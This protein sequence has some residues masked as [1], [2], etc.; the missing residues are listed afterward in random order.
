MIISVLP[1]IDFPTISFIPSISINEDEHI[2]LQLDEFVYDKDH[3][4]S[5]LTWSVIKNYEKNNNNSLYTS[6]YK[7]SRRYLSTFLNQE[8]LL[9]NDY[10]LN[11]EDVI[12]WVEI[13]SKNQIARIQ[14]PPNYFG[15]DIPILLQV[16]DPLNAK[17]IK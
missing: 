5:L 14:P 17:D 10:S 7:N 11:N 6:L 15:T 9:P 12:N 4:D 1:V 2:V 8:Y 16:E 13:D 3:H